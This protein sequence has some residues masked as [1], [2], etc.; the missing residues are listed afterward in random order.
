MLALRSRVR[1]APCLAPRARGSAR[2]WR[3]SHAPCAAPALARRSAGN[4]LWTFGKVG[5]VPAVLTCAN[6]AFNSRFESIVSR[7]D[8]L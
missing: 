8:D 2:Q 7:L 4:L 6:S 5:V 3:G 1:D